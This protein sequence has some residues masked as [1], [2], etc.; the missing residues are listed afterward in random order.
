MLVE[1]DV[2]HG[3]CRLRATIHMFSPAV[4]GNGFK[5]KRSGSAVHQEAVH[6]RFQ[7]F[8]GLLMVFPHR[9]FF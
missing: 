6:V 4:C 2:E 3:T 9:R 5:L 7:V 1:A 8:V